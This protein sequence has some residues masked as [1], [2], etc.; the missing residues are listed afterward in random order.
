VE[1][2]RPSLDSIAVD[3][4]TDGIVSPSASSR[5]NEDAPG[6]SAKSS[7]NH[8]EMNDQLAETQPACTI[9]SQIRCR[10]RSIGGIF[11]V[12]AN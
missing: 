10:V 7:E 3:N 1:Q 4:R 5:I 2:G 8:T 9:A 11:G 12:L 6:R